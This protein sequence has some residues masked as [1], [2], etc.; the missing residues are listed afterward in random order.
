[1]VLARQGGHAQASQFIDGRRGP[2]RIGRGVPD[3]QLERSPGDPAGVVDVADGQLE[4]GEQVPARLDPA[5]PG[6]RNKRTDPDVLRV[7]QPFTDA[8]KPRTSAAGSE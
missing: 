4:P 1:M 3:H 2:L 7:D 8:T 6:Q 5:G